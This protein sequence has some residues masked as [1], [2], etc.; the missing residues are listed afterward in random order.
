MTTPDG[1]V[2]ECPEC[3]APVDAMTSDAEIQEDQPMVRLWPDGPLVPDPSPYETR[4]VVASRTTT[5]VPCGHTRT[6]D[7][8][9]NPRWT[10]IG[11]R[12]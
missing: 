5:F 6:T 10:M 11:R 2:W 4:F 3:G 7:A 1:W 12:A 8:D 9:G